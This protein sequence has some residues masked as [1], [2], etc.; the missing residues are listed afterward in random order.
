MLERKIKINGKYKHFKGH[1][2][3]VIG[4]AKDSETLEEKVVYENIETK[5]LW[6]RNK[7]EFLSEVDKKKYPN[8]EQIYRFELID[9]Q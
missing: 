6:I 2:Y 9:K 5:E 4:L 1:I 8:V 7:E 3:Q